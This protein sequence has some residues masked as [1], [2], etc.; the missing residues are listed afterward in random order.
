MGREA[1]SAVTMSTIG[2][3]ADDDLYERVAA[4]LE[5]A[6]SRVARTVN[7]AMV[8]AYWLI[9]RE[10]VEVEQQ[11]RERARTVRAS[12]GLSQYG[13]RPGSEPA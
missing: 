12:C 2:G 13:S 1:R 3:G 10:I 4:I 8:H 5:D 11:G 9:G 7:T 6:R